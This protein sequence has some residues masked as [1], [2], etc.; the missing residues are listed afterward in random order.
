MSVLAW[1]CVV[2]FVVD[3]AMVLWAIKLAKASAAERAA[4]LTA[5]QVKR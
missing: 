4:V 3:V 1:L 5:L 2:L